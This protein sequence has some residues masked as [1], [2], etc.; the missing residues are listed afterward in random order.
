MPWNETCRMELEVGFCRRTVTSMTAL[1]ED[2]GI[3]RKTGYKWLGGE[4]RPGAAWWSALVR[5]TVMVG[6]WR[7]RWPK[8]CC[9]A[10]AA[11][12]LGSA[13][14]A[15]LMGERPDRPARWAICCVRKGW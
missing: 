7:R 9:S 4:S 1:C 15:R 5:R 12:P 10:Q 3:S 2:Y 6:R 13:Q 11:S 8:D 14:A